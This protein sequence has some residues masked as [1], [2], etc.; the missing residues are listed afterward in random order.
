MLAPT[1]YA[2][3]LGVATGCAAWRLEIPG[4][5]YHAVGAGATGVRSADMT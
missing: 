5:A 1:W 2:A 4:H 3:V